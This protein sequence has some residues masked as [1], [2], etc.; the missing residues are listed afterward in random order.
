MMSSPADDSIEAFL[1][2]DCQLSGDCLATT[3]LKKLGFKNRHQ[4]Q[5]IL[6]LPSV[7]ESSKLGLP[8]PEDS[9]IIDNSNKVSPK[10]ATRRMLSRLASKYLTLEIIGYAFVQQEAVDL[11]YLCHSYKLLLIRNYQLFKKGVIKAEKKVINSV[12]ELL[13]EKW[14]SKKYRLRYKWAC[15]NE[16]EVADCLALLG[17]RLHFHSIKINRS[18]LPMFSKCKPSKMEIDQCNNIPQLFKD[19]PLSVNYLKLNWH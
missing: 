13:D 19:L 16:N 4:L 9:Q 10:K 12:F 7:K 2:N 14:L 17:D 11:G 5:A 15:D 6:I 8:K 18:L 1:I 3:F